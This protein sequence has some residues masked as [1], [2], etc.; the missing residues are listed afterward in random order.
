MTLRTTTALALLAGVGLAGTAGLAGPA[1]AEDY[2][3]GVMSAQSGYLT[4]YDQ[5]SYAGFKYCVDKMNEAGGMAGKYNVILDV[6]DTRSDMAESVKV[7]QE[8]I[9][10]GAQFIVASAD[11]D[12]TIAAGQISEPAQIPTMSFAGTAPVMTQ[13]GEYIFGAYP[14]DNQ[15]AT[16]LADFATEQGL[17]EGLHPEVARCGLHHGR[18]GIFRR[19]VRGER[20]RGC[21]REPLFAQPA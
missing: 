6:R 16:V 18:P 14:A 4:P 19:G 15:Q 5:P 2:K 3:I 1:F 12:P 13:V 21:R 7:T 8:M 11:A 20:R 9:D 10:N 17:Y